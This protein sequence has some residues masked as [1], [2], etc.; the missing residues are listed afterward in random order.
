MNQVDP[1]ESGQ[2]ETPAV[3]TPSADA[4]SA[5]SPSPQ[6]PSPSLAPAVADQFYEVKIG[7]QTRKVPLNELLSGYSRTQD[8][9]QKTMA[10]A[11]ERRKLE[12]AMDAERG[13]YKSF[14]SDPDNV[15]QLHDYLLAQ[16]GSQQSPNQP[17]T[18]QQYNALRAAEQ[19]RQAQEREQMFAE[20]ETKQL[21][22]SYKAEVDTTIKTIL[23]THPELRSIHMIDTILKMSAARKDP[24]TIEDAVSHMREFAKEQ[25]DRI[26]AQFAEQQKAVA[27]QKQNLTTRGTEPPGGAAPMP[28]AKPAYK[29][30]DPRLAADATEMLRQLMNEKQ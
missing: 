20:L 27:I 25:S 8:Y 12:Q 26:R 5:S 21:Q 1:M 18:I 14:L 13:Q 17:L 30:G 2:G 28:S 24:A 15:K 29:L 22:H 23:D 16:R 11:E 3:D 7:G 9:T 10:L 4:S 19:Q 6:A